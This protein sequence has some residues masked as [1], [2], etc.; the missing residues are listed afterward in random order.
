M[1]IGAAM[2]AGV[3]GVAGTTII[4]SM[5]PVIGLPR[6]NLAGV[7]GTWLLPP[8]GRAALLGLTLHFVFGAG[9]ALIYAWLWSRDIGTAS[10]EWGIMFGAVHGLIAA[11]VVPFLLH[12]YP[13]PKEML[14]GPA[15]LVA[16]FVLHVLFGLIV[17]LQYRALVG[18]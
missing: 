3:V 18:E 17:A 14:E 5:M 11:A 12:R 8:G 13:R 10:Y 7:L 6:V 4:H 1:E 2:T 16:L 15:T 9:F